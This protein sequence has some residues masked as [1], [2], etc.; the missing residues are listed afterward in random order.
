MM[1]KHKVMDIAIII[2]INQDMIIGMGI[3]PTIQIITIT[4]D[5]A[6]AIG[7]TITI[8]GIMVIITGVIITIIGTIVIITG[9]ETTTTM[10][11]T[12]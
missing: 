3:L 9:E 8:I 11:I 1:F 5:T 7:I 4:G 6:I 2:I 10:V 12:V